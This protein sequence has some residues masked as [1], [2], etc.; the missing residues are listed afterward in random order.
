MHLTRQFPLVRRIVGNMKTTTATQAKGVYERI[1]ESGIWWIRYADARG[2]EHREKVGRRG[3]AI[4]LFS[5]RKT[6]ALQRKKLPERFRAKGV[7]FAKLC[8][9]AIE[10][11]T[12]ANAPKSAYELG[13]KVAELLPKFGDL[14]A[15]DIT[16]QEIVRWLT[17][18]AKVRN[19]KA[20]S[21]N[22][23]EAALSLIFRV[24]IDNDKITTNPASRIR[25][26]TENNH[27]V[28]LLSNEEEN[29]LR[30]TITEPR[31][32]AA[33]E[34][35]IYTGMRQSEQYTLRWSQVDLDKRLV[36]LP[37]TKNGK[38]RY[39]PMNDTVVAAFQ[40][41]KEQGRAQSAPVFPGRNGEAAQGARGWFKDAVSRA[42][43]VDYSWHCNRHTFASRLVM[44]GVDLRTVGELL[45]HRTAQMR[46]RYAHLAPS[47]TASAV[48][49]LQVPKP[50]PVVSDEKDLPV[51]SL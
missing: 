38:P 13:L 5:K 9:D 4:D 3:D 44:A 30:A 12:P 46:M 11:S 51:S 2:K 20:S 43:L 17:E 25:R 23:W 28:R 18:Q 19:W 41:L 16:K 40:S 35:S 34:I 10:H 32:L 14:R 21:R 50:V 1:P 45:G 7:T 33:L 29:A 31:L 49:R 39:V 47:P 15:E 48:N 24:G 37:K 36:F 42:G 22:R 26:K 8:A 6:E 27:R